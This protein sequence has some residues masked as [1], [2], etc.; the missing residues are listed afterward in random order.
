MPIVEFSTTTPALLSIIWCALPPSM[1][2]TR[3]LMPQA[4]A[5]ALIK[6]A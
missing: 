6:P 3:L 1:K 4:A 2:C 5:K